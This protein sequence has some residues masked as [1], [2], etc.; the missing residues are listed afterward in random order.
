M[1]VEGW[2]GVNIKFILALLSVIPLVRDAA[3]TV[4]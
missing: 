1:V 2:S 4:V 3:G